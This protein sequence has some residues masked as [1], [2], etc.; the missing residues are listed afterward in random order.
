MAGL[1]GLGRSVADHRP[2]DCA[3][4]ASGAIS[5][6]RAFSKSCRDFVVEQRERIGP[7]TANGHLVAACRTDTPARMQPEVIDHTEGLGISI[8]TD[9]GGSGSRVRKLY[10]WGRHH[11]SLVRLSGGDIVMTYVV[12]ARPQPAHELAAN[13]ARDLRWALPGVQGS[14]GS[15]QGERHRDGRGLISTNAHQ[16]PEAA[17]GGA[18]VW[19]ASSAL[20]RT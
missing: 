2:E 4:H 7:V 1:A 13:V 15:A 11:P 17:P 9:D 3:G 14:V 5:D 16:K 10:D 18:A 19:R 20:L 12:R 8:S 6:G